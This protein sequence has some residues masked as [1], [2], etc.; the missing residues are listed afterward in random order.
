VLYTKTVPAD[1]SVGTAT[2][3]LRRHWTVFSIY[4]PVSFLPTAPEFPVAPGWHQNGNGATL[5]RV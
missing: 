2:V 5:H 3:F 4:F 1:D